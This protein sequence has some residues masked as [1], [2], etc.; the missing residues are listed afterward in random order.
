[1]TLRITSQLFILGASV[2]VGGLMAPPL[3]PAQIGGSPAHAFECTNAGVGGTA[4]DDSG[5][6]GNTAC[7]NGA[8]V[9]GTSF[10]T[11]VGSGARATAGDASAFGNGAEATA[12]ES[13]AIGTDSDAQF[14]NTTA[15]GS[16][17]NTGE[18]DAPAPGQP[19]TDPSP[20]VA[21]AQPRTKTGP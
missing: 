19:A 10:G 2:A 20:L 3:I 15:V 17:A 21:A 7:G 12:T 8:V 14:A 5:Q 6:S 16:D 1:M 11:A 4:P 9:S 13:T 18:A